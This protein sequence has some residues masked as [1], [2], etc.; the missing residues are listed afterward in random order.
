[1][2]EYITEAQAKDIEAIIESAL[3]TAKATIA[4]QVEAIV[5]YALP[6]NPFKLGD[7]VVVPADAKC[8][9]HRGQAEGGVYF[10]EET[11]G[12]IIADYSGELTDANGNLRVRGTKGFSQF[13][14]PQFLALAKAEP[15]GKFAVG[16]RLVV[17]SGGVL[18]KID[19]TA[20]VVT[21][22]V[23]AEFGSERL[24]F[25]YYMSKE[26]PAGVWEAFLKAAPEPEWAVGDRVLV[27]GQAGTICYVEESRCCGDDEV[28]VDVDG[29]TYPEWVGF[30][31][32]ESLDERE[33]APAGYV[34]VGDK[35]VLATK[36]GD[37]YADIAVGETVTVTRVSGSSAWAL[38]QAETEDGR[39][40][41]R[42]ALRFAR[43]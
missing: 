34:Q 8:L 30:D 33:F 42:Y 19:G 18:G 24:G 36:I 23:P 21:E 7:K 12:E 5:K 28:K 31:D 15:V 1:M 17:A 32:L 10:G 27:N 3:D 41:E 26:R 20:I 43:A 38:V 40:T 29:E 9:N 14:A 22:V 2:T 4:S 37:G 16:D 25:F 39:T 11:E 13:V 35:L 6:D